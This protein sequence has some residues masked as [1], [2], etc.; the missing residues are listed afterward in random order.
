MYHI[1]RLANGLKVATIEMPGKD[2]VAA[3]VWVKVGGRYE[4]ATYAGISH[5]VEHMLFKGT[6]NRNT[7]EI[8]EDVE[9]VGG[10]INAF[11]AEELTCY[12]VK[13][14]KNHFHLAIDVLSDMINNPLFLQSEIDKE[15]GV[16]LEEIKMYLDLPSQHVHEL[17]GTMLWPD[18]P[19]GLLL[20]G[21]E[22]SVARIKRPNL[23]GFIK[24][25]Y[26]PRN[27]LLTVAGDVEHSETMK[28]AEKYFPAPDKSDESEFEKARISQT[29][30]NLMLVDKK[31]E[32]THFVI[33]LHGYS[34]NHPL[35]YRASLLN[36]IM[37]ANM[38]SRLFEEVREKRGLAYE[39]RSSNNFLQD[40]GSFTISAGVETKKAPTAIKVI[41]KELEKI[42][43]KP[44]SGDELKRAKDYFLGQF[45]MGLEDTLDHMSW[46]GER[47]LYTGEIPN[48]YEIE[49]EINRM[50]AEDI[51]EAARDIFQNNHLN[52][53]LIGPLADKSKKQISKDF[54]LN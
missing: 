13:M 44:V 24:R 22:K 48:R 15:R 16:I 45:C 5:F 10:M 40:T 23:V 53:A 39:I 50:T 6:K 4:N 30:P 19:L 8:K 21:D 47:V 18:Q 52:L 32:Q 35:R 41:L 37:G 46:I 43:N 38:S 9:G 14:L 3:G 11:T 1:D 17:I 36:I 27:I 51:S 54:T 20:A 42:K 49:K 7:R 34:R 29:K 28:L 2:S 26:H 33:G 31:T 12:F 25:N